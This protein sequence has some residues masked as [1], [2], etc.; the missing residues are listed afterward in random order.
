MNWNKLKHMAVSSVEIIRNDGS[1]TCRYSFDYID[2]AT[3]P[4]RIVRRGLYLWEHYEDYNRRRGVIRGYYFKG[5]K[6]EDTPYLTYMDIK[7][8][9]TK[10][11]VCQKKHIVGQG[12]IL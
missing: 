1:Y 12:L 2:Q 5:V 11:Y 3:K 8:I 4:W 6:E 9:I 7:E 10:C